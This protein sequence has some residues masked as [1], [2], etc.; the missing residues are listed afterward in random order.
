MVYVDSAF[1]PFRRMKMCHMIA[2]TLEEL[3]G[4]A[5]AVGM[6]REWF[7]VNASFPH[8]DIAKSRRKRAIELGAVVLERRAYFGV[9]DKLRASPAFMAEWEQA[10]ATQID[11]V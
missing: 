8:Y 4:M 5:E 2:D 6:R 11:Q 7:Q 10:L 3:H 1:I 9:V